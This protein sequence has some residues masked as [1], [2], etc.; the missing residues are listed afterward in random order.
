MEKSRLA[1]AYPP[2]A[3]ED[4]ANRNARSEAEVKHGVIVSRAELRRTTHHA[5]E[6]AVIPGSA[7]V[8]PYSEESYEDFLLR[9]QDTLR[10]LPEL[11]TADPELLRGE[12]Q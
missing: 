11:A 8:A 6:V 1:E 9:L 5:G 3:F 12:R 2:E 7:F 4:D 10:R